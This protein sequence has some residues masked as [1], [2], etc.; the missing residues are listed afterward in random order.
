MRRSIEWT[1]AETSALAQRLGLKRVPQVR[2]SDEIGSPQVFGLWSP[3]VLMPAETIT[4]FSDSSAGN[5]S[6]PT[7]PKPKYGDRPGSC[8]VPKCR[9][10]IIG[11]PPSGGGVFGTS[12]P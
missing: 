8:V 9:P 5:T 6:W 2:L 1:D 7:K 12:V 11:Y 4:A 3:V 10:T